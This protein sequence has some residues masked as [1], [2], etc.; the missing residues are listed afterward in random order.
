[1]TH[2]EC[3]EISNLAGF[4]LCAVREHIAG[5]HEPA[6]AVDWNNPAAL[7]GFP[8]KQRMLLERIV[9]LRREVTVK[10]VAAREI[11]AGRNLDFSI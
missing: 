9:S 8:L 4:M 2:D 11:A 3:L 5:G 1:M 10:C 6:K 7:N